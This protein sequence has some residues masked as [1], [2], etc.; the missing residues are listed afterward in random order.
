MTV[1]EKVWAC[2][3]K[4]LSCSSR[5]CEILPEKNPRIH[6]DIGVTAALDM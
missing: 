3:G 2:V 4:F 6:F 5:D 1:E